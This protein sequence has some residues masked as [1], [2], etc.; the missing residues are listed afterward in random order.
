MKGDIT[1]TLF[2][3][4][5]LSMTKN[6]YQ[7]IGDIPL[8]NSISIQS[9]KYIERIIRSVRENIM[10]KPVDERDAYVMTLL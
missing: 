9:N 4:G 10:S 5:V 2:D 1:A 8:G 3:R 7:L 6:S